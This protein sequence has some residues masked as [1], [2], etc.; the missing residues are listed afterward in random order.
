MATAKKRTNIVILS[1]LIAEKGFTKQLDFA[2]Q[3]KISRPDL[4]RII[5]GQKLPSEEEA[6]RI[7]EALKGVKNLESSFTKWLT[8]VKMSLGRKKNNKK[9]KK[10]AK[11]GKHNVKKNVAA[12]APKPAKQPVKTKNAP[13]MAEVL[14]KL[15]ELTG[16]PDELILMVVKFYRK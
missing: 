8:S 16:I 14:G 1:E 7:K 10:G 12:A 11:K 2:D 9:T 15:N 6:T 4:S 13:G 3:V 5:R